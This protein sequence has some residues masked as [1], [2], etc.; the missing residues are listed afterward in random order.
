M[1]RTIIKAISLHRPS[2]STTSFL[3]LASSVT[4]SSLDS[5]EK[6]TFVPSPA[7][8]AVQASRNYGTMLRHHRAETR[9]AQ[10]K[11]SISLPISKEEPCCCSA[12]QQHPSTAQVSEQQSEMEGSVGSIYSTRT[13]ATETEA[14]P[15]SAD[16][17]FEYDHV[18]ASTS[19]YIDRLSIQTITSSERSY[20]FF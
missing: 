13:W 2:E 5:D 1:A 3:S 7:K 6:T 8:K 11:R 15:C 18:D 14:E 16:D 4:S 19:R 10:V 9:I 20:T 17:V 12:N